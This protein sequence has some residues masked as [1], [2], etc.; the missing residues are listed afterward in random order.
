LRDGVVDKIYTNN[1]T[2]GA[3]A[4]Q[5]IPKHKTVIK[6]PRNSICFIGRNEIGRNET[7]G[8]DCMT[9]STTHDNQQ[10]ARNKMELT[11]TAEQ[12]NEFIRTFKIGVLKQLHSKKLLS[13]RQLKQL[14]S[15][16]K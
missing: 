13:D 12:G 7:G 14:I 4:L 16:Q 1:E 15:L 5:D 10:N 8:A 2:L 3:N 9:D 11:L 6:Q